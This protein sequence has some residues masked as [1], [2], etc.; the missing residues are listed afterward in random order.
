MR[1][2]F[3]LIAFICLALVV[4][5][6]LAQ[7]TGEISGVVR[8]SSGAPLPGATVTIT[9]PQMPN[10]RSV[11]TLSD[12]AFRFK[13]LPPGTYHLKSQLTGMGAFDQDVVVALAKSTEVHPSIRATA[14][15]SIEV[16][17]AVPLVD[18]KASDISVVTSK[19]TIEKLPLARTFT[20]TFQLA[21]G[22]AD[23]RSTAPNAGGG[24]QDNTFL[25]DG[26]NI[27]NAFFGDLYQDFSELDIKEVSITRAGV[28]PEYGRTGGFIVNAVTKSGSNTVHGEAR[29][30]TAS[31]AGRRRGRT[32]HRRARQRGS[33]RRD[34]GRT[35]RWD[36]LS[37]TGLT[38]GSTQRDRINTLDRSPFYIY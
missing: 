11:T 25:Y 3:I 38:R 18:T 32:R 27:T 36:H 22:V 24:R 1:F 5:L 17:A 19:D 37:S 23:N 29:F 21:P 14:R 35:D 15:E 12:G 26:V 8:D 13:D 6:A 20:G 31:P 7:T 10:G 2:R 16:T 9:G 33:S 4:P 30:S 28:T 34:I